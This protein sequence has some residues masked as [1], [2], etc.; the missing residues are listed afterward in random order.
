LEELGSPWAGEQ[1]E[2]RAGRRGT[3]VAAA[4]RSQRS[5]DLSSYEG[6]VATVPETGVERGIQI[7]IT[8]IKKTGDIIR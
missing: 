7:R 1:E 6:L 5:P 3:S 8:T 2:K 4:A